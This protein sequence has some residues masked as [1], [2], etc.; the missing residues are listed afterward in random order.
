MTYCIRIQAQPFGTPASGA[1]E[2]VC[3]WRAACQIDA[4]RH[5]CV[6]SQQV[7]SCHCLGARGVRLQ[8]LITQREV[9]KPA[10]TASVK[11]AKVHMEAT[12]VH[13]A[14]LFPLQL[15]SRFRALARMGAGESNDTTSGERRLRCKRAC[16]AITSACRAMLDMVHIEG[17]RV[18]RHGAR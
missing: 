11:C 3:M 8:K 6:H 18:Q 16:S 14:P 1:S 2:Q 7:A 10:Y 5:T 9:R 17:W 13:L 12:K 15:L 4:C